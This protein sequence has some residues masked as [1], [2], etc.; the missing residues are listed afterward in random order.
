MSET[1]KQWQCGDVRSLCTQRGG[2]LHPYQADLL[3]NAKNL[4]KKVNLAIDERQC[5]LLK[6]VHY[7]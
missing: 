2:Y 1:T 4:A 5:I 3:N 7:N 6:K